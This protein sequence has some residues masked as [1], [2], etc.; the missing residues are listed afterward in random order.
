MVSQPETVLSCISCDN[1]VNLEEPPYCDYRQNIDRFFCE[2]CEEKIWRILWIASRYDVPL[3]LYAPLGDPRESQFIAETSTCF[4]CEEVIPVFWWPGVALSK[5]EPP[6]PKP[7]T[8]RFMHSVEC[9]KICWVNT[10]G[11][12]GAIQ[13]SA[14]LYLD[15]NAPF[16]SLQAKGM[17]HDA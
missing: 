12:C 17:H 7:H 2:G 11:N 5:N 9:G 13:S 4:Y 6:K 15:K 1:V 14:A 10:C 3:K 8:I 16:I